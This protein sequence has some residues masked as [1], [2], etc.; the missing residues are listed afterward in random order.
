MTDWTLVT[1]ANRGLGLEFV[2]Q[3]LAAG[4]HVV[5]TCRQPGRATA[6][7]PLAGEHPGRLKV[8]PLDITDARSR[9]ELVRE[10]PLVLGAGDRVE[11][12]INNAGV[13]HSGERFGHL[14]AEVLD[15]SLQSNAVGPLL[16][17]EALVASLADGAR[18]ANISSQLGSIGSTTRFGTPSY[19]IS[20]AALN[21]A[22][23]LLARALA[24]RGI[25]VVA[26]HPGWVRTDMGGAQADLDP[27]D[28]V[29]GLLA[30]IDALGADDSG[31]FLDAAGK[32]LPW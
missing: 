9:A 27:A 4:R 10:L 15:H 19:A 13:L 30:R 6:L 1:G 18:I 29:A 26:L 11:R 20:K 2:R 5:A 32:T 31:R 8:L 25:V 3:S 14:S 21:M 12:L 22:T 28:A 17:T 7:N 23:V 16:L 24:E